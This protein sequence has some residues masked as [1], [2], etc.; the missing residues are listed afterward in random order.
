M[1]LILVYQSSYLIVDN[2]ASPSIQELILQ[3]NDTLPK[4]AIPYE[5][6]IIIVMFISSISFAY[7]AYKLYQEFGWSIYKKIGADMAMRGI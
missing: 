4:D 7:L 5:I 6:C 3:Q 1:K 2:G